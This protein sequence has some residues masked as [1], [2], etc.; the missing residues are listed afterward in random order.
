MGT[1]TDIQVGS[2]VLNMIENVPSTISGA[3]LW[4]ITDNEIYYAE[5]FT[6]DTIGTTAIAQEYQPAIIS[7]SAASVLRMMEMTGADVS[8]IR[9]G[10]FAISKGASSS[11]STT[12]EALREDGLN[13]LQA[14]GEVCNYYKALG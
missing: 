13:K 7:L 3:T 2:I 12:A 11:S 9:L 5:N 4:N 6:G 10:D 1:L 14:L 8:N